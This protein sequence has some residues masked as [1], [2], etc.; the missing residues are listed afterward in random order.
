MLMLT[1][2]YLLSD[3]LDYEDFTAVAKYDFVAESPAELSFK[4]GDIISLLDIQDEV[5]W[6]GQIGDRIGMF[7][8]NHVDFDDHDEDTSEDTG[9]PAPEVVVALFDFTAQTRT[10]LSFKAG[11]RITVLKGNTKEV[12]WLGRLGNREGTFP[13][14][15][16]K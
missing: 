4:R 13:S 14:N 2:S 3:D 16:V 10:E 5:W 9:K 7:P 12:W 8:A 6:K 11:D 1:I 15:Y